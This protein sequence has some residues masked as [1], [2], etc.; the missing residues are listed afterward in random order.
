MIDNHN[1]MH[2]NII[3]NDDGMATYADCFIYFE[4]SL[5]NT[6]FTK[7]HNIRKEPKTEMSLRLENEGIYDS[8]IH[9]LTQT[10]FKL[11]TK[12]KTVKGANKQAI[13][14][15]SLYYACHY[16]GKPKNFK[17]LVLRFKLSKKQASKGLKLCQIAIQESNTFI[18]EYDNYEV[19]D[20]SV[21][22][23]HKQT[24]EELIK[25]YNIPIN[26]YNDIEQILITS[27]LKKNKTLN[28]KITSLWISCIFYWLLK[29]NPY[30]EPEEFISI[31][32]DHNVTLTQLKSH[33]SYLNKTLQC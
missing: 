13:I 4:K 19:G 26:F 33:L 24:L 20:T 31:N 7:Y 1:C 12:N 23:T 17:D 8:D 15:A 3:K 10:I 2:N 30:V 28:N 25:K 11:V 16:K 14:F 5:D 21:L 6:E 32:N 27:H 22:C 9:K 29:I 18:K